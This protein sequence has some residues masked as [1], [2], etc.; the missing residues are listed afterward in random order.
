MKWDTLY[1]RHEQKMTQPI[2]I[3]EEHKLLDNHV[4][5]Q[6]FY[7]VRETPNL[8]RND[9][10][11]VLDNVL[12]KEQCEILIN[13]FNNSKFSHVSD[14]GYPKEYRD[15]YRYIYEDATLSKF[16]FTSIMQFVEDK[17]DNTLGECDSIEEAKLFLGKWNLFSLNPMFRICKYENGGKFE[18]HYD[19]FYVQDKENRS[20]KTFMIY[21]NDN[22]AGTTFIDKNITIKPKMG[23]CVIFNHYI[24]HRGERVIGEKYIMR[25]DIMYKIQEYIE[26]KDPAYEEYELGK[27][28]ES[29]GNMEEAIK[30]YMKAHRLNP[31]LL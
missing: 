31:N 7:A 8:T 11:I 23:S 28:Y 5:P 27:K 6:S 14:D 25:S 18:S 21:L 26:H 4:I 2:S 3:C 30:H 20:F 10:I 24:L 1:K 19:G 16:L 12:S 17:I 29:A 9:E 15:N 13:F 22:D